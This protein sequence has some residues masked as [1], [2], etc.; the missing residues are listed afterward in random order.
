MY[1]YPEQNNLDLFK[2]LFKGRDDVFAI[3]WEKGAKSGYMPA[4]SYDP[5]VY[6]LHKIKGGTFKNYKDKTYLPLTDIQLLKHLNGEQL[7]GIYPLLKNNASW[8]IAADFDGVKWEQQCNTF[9]EACKKRNVPAYLERSRSGNGGHVWIFFDQCYPAIR[10]RKIFIYLL[11][12]AG[13][14]SIFDN[15]SS[16]D[17]LFPNQDFHSGKG[18]GNLIALPLYKPAL[19]SG[20][21]C[22]VDEQMKPYNDQWEFLSAVK[23]VS[24][25]HLDE[26]FNEI[27]SKK[28]SVQTIYHSGKLHITLNN[29]I[30]LNRAGLTPDL[31]TY[32]KEELNFANSDYFVKKNTGRNTWGTER[33]FKFID[34]TEDEIIVPRGFAGKLFRFCRQQKIDF[35]FHDQRRLQHPVKYETVLNLRAYQRPALEAASHKDFGIITAPPGAGKTVIGL[36][37]IAEKQQP[38]LIIVH[39]KHLLDQWVE[40][41]QAFLGIPGKEIGKVNQGKV[42]QGNQVTVAM[43]QSLGKYLDQEDTKD[44][45]QSFGTIII[46]ECHHIPA[47]TYWGTISKLKPYYQYGLT[48]T[49]FRKGSDGKLIFIHLGEIISHIKPQDKAAFERPRVII[50]ETALD[51]PFNPKTDELEILSKILVHDTARNKMICSDISAELNN[52]KKVVVITERK[53]H[54]NI[55][56]QFLKKSY[57]V[58]KL[59]GDDSIEKRAKKWELLQGGEYQALITTG[60]YFGEGTDLQNASCLFLVYPFSFK[61]KLIQYIGRVQR[62]ER[63]PVIYDYR[64]RKIEYLNKL[65]LKRNT[66]Y[67]HFD[68]QASLFADMET[69][70]GSDDNKFKLEKKIKVPIDKLD[71][72]YGGITFQICFI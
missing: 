26:V 46:D 36:K 7:I 64:D 67:R 14:I 48:A 72:I 58:I 62:S 12:E 68:R 17:R 56:Y 47:R 31:I 13:A 18:L 34:E 63:T 19:E 61:G 1:P 50:K 30:H 52:G 65:F 5:Y 25:S 29:F 4:Y 15:D 57:E 27:H 54:I 71:F 59:S 24:V 60:Q 8:F 33:Y 28:D 55:L 16:F 66:Y 38:A 51:F 6:R 44:F 9:I 21:S 41:I 53:E 69:I 2:N 70:E 3:R 49:P 37:I 11:K 20:N 32:L 42:K 39:R 40:R 35:E 45:A 43:I 10:S 22:F 23:R